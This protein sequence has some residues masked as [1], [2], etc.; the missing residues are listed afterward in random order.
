MAETKK[1]KVIIV[2]SGPAGFSAGI[3]LARANLEPLMLEGFMAGGMPGGQLMTTDEVENYPGY[4]D[5]VGGQELMG[6]MRQHAVNAGVRMNMVDVTEVDLSSRPFK[7]VDMNGDAYEADAIIVATGA[8]AKRLKM[9]SEEAFWNKGISACAVCDGALP[10]FR[11][12]PL[13]VIGGGDTA[14]EEAEHLTKFG[15]KVYLIHRRDELRASQV[16]QK[17]AMEHDK[18]EILWNKVPEEFVGDTVLEGIKLKDTQTGEVSLLDVNGAFEAIGHSP[19]TGFLAGQVETDEVGYI[20]VKAGTNETSV[21]GVFAA[22]DVQDPHWRQAVIAAGSGAQA[23]L[24][25]ER[26]LMEQE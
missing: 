24:T 1:E 9:P 26:W 12:K 10:L 16:L 19:N 15:S 20:T 7:V 11:D 6:N 21:P 22:G 23:A 18:I 17:R 14:V 2:G 3:Y 5:G 13:A 25:A 4:Q 8:T